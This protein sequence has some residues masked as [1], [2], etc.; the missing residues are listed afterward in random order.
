ME[1]LLHFDELDSTNSYLK[2]TQENLPHGTVVTSARQTAGRGRYSRIWESERGGLYFSVLLKPTKTDFLPNLTQLMSVCVCR[3]LESFGLLV[4]IKW[5]NDVLVNGQ[6]ICGILSEAV[7][8]E[9]RIQAVVLG[10]GLNVGQSNLASISQPAVS[11]R[12]LGIQAET[13]VLLKKILDFFWRDY[14]V[15]LE[16]GFPFIASAY[17]ERFGALGKE[18]TVQNGN[19]TL[20]GMVEDLSPRGALLLRTGQHLQELFTGDLM[21]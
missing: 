17:K 20:F 15:L 12:E 3:T 2:K 7:S 4:Q 19:E 9:G 18:V 1:H 13:N 11:L 5:P 21:V 16:K 8:R 10:V 14:P 6:K